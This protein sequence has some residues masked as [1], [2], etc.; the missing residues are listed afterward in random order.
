M[1][2]HLKSPGDGCLAPHCVAPACFALKGVKYLPLHIS[3]LHSEPDSTFLFPNSPLPKGDSVL[4]AS[5]SE[6]GEEARQGDRKQAMF[7]IKL[8]ANVLL[9]D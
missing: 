7:P 8:R 3:E 4:P 2:S 1:T 9:P 5:V 6:R